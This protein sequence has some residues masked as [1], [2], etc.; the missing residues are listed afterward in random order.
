[1][2]LLHLASDRDHVDIVKLLL[3]FGMDVNVKD[4]FGDSPLD[5]ANIANSQN[6]IDLLVLHGGVANNTTHN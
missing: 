1:M 5:V 3:E 6:C 2:T 4:N